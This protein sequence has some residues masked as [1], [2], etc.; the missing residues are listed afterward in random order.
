MM[1]QTG[2]KK[3]ERKK[4]HDSASGLFKKAKH[5]SVTRKPREKPSSIKQSDDAALVT[6]RKPGLHEAETSDEAAD[7]INAEKSNAEKGNA[8]K[9]NAE[10][11]NAEEDGE[12][13]GNYSTADEE[14][15]DE[16]TVDVVPVKGALT[17]PSADTQQK[18]QPQQGEA[19]EQQE[20]EQHDWE[21]EQL[22]DLSS[23]NRLGAQRRVQR[24]IQEYFSSDPETGELIFLDD[25]TS[26]LKG[27]DLRRILNF[28][29]PLRGINPK[30][31]PNGFAAVVEVIRIRKLTKPDL[32][33][34]ENVNMLLREYGNKPTAYTKRLKELEIQRLEIKKIAD[35]LK[36]SYNGPQ[37]EGEAAS[38]STAAGQNWQPF[39]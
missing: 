32:Y 37:G 16:T 10:K 5:K 7:K 1:Q 26:R 23:G 39:S 11:S 17:T 24:L 25:G 30:A 22:R 13:S 6:T 35:G 27:S 20:H 36:L 33:P 12:E 29:V 3:R 9:S 34:N 4:D 31:K 21:E 8:E 28:L 19:Q 38:T 18:Q 2:N 15:D 14:D